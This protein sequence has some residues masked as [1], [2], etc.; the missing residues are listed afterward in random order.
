[1]IIHEAKEKDLRGALEIIG[2]LNIIKQKS[3]AIRIEEV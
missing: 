3:V 1:M 2:C